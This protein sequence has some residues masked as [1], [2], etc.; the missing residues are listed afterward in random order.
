[1]RG[2]Q[3][4][5]YYGSHYALQASR[6]YTVPNHVT[7][8]GRYVICVT[9]CPGAAPKNADPRHFLPSAA[10]VL[11]TGTRDGKI[12]R[13]A[14][15]RFETG[16]CRDHSGKLW[17]AGWKGVSSWNGTRFVAD[18]AVGSWLRDAIGCTEVE[19][20]P[21]LRQPVNP[22]LVIDARQRENIVVD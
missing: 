13:F 7:T 2:G 22:P 5:H 3:T 1:M 15:G 18:K 17:T 9:G 12:A 6:R 4:W 14:H 11:W 19:W 10:I 16:V 21:F 8:A 20:T